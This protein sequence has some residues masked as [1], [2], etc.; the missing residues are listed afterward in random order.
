VLL[1][2]VRSVTFSFSSLERTYMLHFTLVRS[3]LEYTFVVWNSITSG[4]IIII[5]NYYYYYY[6]IRQIFY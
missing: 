3:E 1:S 2:I 4:I 6:Y 5:I